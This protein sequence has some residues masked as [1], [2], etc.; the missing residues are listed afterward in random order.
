MDIQKLAYESLQYLKS[1]YD[2]PKSGFIAGGCLANLVWE[3][4]SGTVAKIN[5]IDVYVFDKQIQLNDSINKKQ[6][7][8]S[9]EAYI[10]DNYQGICYIYYTKIHY[11]ID[12]VDR[13]GMIN[14]IYYE[15]DKKCPEIILKFFDI[16]C[17]QIGYDI[18]E[19]KFYWTPEFVDFIQTGKLKIVNLSTPAH[20]VIRLVK[21]KDELKANFDQIELDMVEYCIETKTFFDSN[22][23]KFKDRY[24]DIYRKYE[25]ELSKRFELIR[26]EETEQWLATELNINDRIWKLKRRSPTSIFDNDSN[27]KTIHRSVDFI[28]YIRNIFGNRELENIW[29][30]IHHLFNKEGK[31]QDYLDVCISSQDLKLLYNLCQASP[32]SINNLIGLKISEQLSII[33]SLLNKY[34]GDPLIALVLLENHS[35]EEI[36]SQDEFGMMLLELS[37]RK[38]ILS[39]RKGKVKKLFDAIDN[40]VV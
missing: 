40:P 15:S 6:H 37:H 10:Y 25:S 39:D 35:V 14:T 7:F 5:D 9:K 27:I 30:N 1:K 24:A 17:C 19:D 31:L 36:K 11:V 38:D 29:N 8:K 26:D 16:N 4:V 34:I 23:I 12:R 3:K 33:K 13:Q 20:T 2:L 18:E 28:F 21:K 22:K 32:R